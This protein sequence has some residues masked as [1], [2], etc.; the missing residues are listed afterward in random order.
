MT[1]E[2]KFRRLAAAAATALAALAPLAPGLSASAQEASGDA[3]AAVTVVNGQTFGAWTVACQ[4]LGVNRTSCVL[5][6][7]LVRRADNAFLAEILAF[8]NADDSKRFLAARVPNGVY[9][10]AGFALRP[11]DSEEETR[12]VWQSCSAR[13]CEALV[14]LT[15]ELA[16]SLEAASGGLVAGYKPSIQGEPVIFAFSAEGLTA[17]LD[18]LAQA[19]S[20][21]R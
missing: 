7:R 5:S 9:L 15:P 21:A 20:E 17:G 8:A 18:A 10:P 1:P 3:P 4:A 6:Q 2:G 11:A 16:Q 19:A 13:L 12:F 14:E